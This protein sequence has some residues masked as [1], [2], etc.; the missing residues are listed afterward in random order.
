MVAMIAEA[1]ETAKAELNSVSVISSLSIARNSGFCMFMKKYAWPVPAAVFV[2][3]TSPPYS[4]KRRY[5]WVRE[6]LPSFGAATKRS[7]SV[8][9]LIPGSRRGYSMVSSVKSA[10]VCWKRFEIATW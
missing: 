3:F 7:G 8:A 5:T 9:S 4:L 10:T 6:Q 1:A 2:M